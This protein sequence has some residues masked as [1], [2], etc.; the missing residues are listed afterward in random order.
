MSNRNDVLEKVA[1][2]M[3]EESAGIAVGFE[4]E[5]NNSTFNECNFSK[6]H[7][8]KMKNMFRR[9][10]RKVAFKKISKYSKGIAAGVVAVV[11]VSG[12]AVFSVEAWRTKVMNFVFNDKTTHTEIS[13]VENSETIIAGDIYFK[14]IPKGFEVIEEDVSRTSTDIVFHD[15]NTKISYQKALIRIEKSIDTENAIVKDI[16]INGMEGIVSKKSDKIILVWH[17]ED[18][19]YTMTSSGGN[20]PIS[21]EE[22]VKMAQNT[23]KVQKEEKKTHTFKDVHFKYIPE[24]FKVTEEIASRISTDVIFHDGI[25]EISYH[26]VPIFV[27]SAI[28]TENAIVKD[29]TINGM[30]GIISK[31]DTSI[32]L[33]W[34][35]D[36][37]VYTMTSSGGNGPI[38]E[39][40]IVKIAENIESI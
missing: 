24:G 1:D 17:D 3:F 4:D 19:V 9:E 29:V 7:E 35:D 2:M 21:E 34:H 38:S 28:D 20:G 16:K 11:I 37:Y 15:G 22:I 13:F 5:K 6:E 8:E 39:E 27:E 14:Y 32:I 30:E 40:E 12:T 33:V 25:T 18:Y 23:E 26:R 31:K 10:K 36:G